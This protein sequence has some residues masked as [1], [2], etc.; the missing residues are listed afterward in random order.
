VLVF[1][2]VLVAPLFL[3]PVVLGG[4]L[5]ALLLFVP[6]FLLWVAR[7]VRAAA[8][9]HRRRAARAPTAGRR[10]S[11]KQFAPPVDAQVVVV[12]LPDPADRVL[13]VAHETDAALVVV[14]TRHRSAVGKFLLGS[15]AQR[16]VLEAACPVLVVKA[17]PV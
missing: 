8:R 2:A 17:E 9:D 4:Y 5:A 12:D 1:L 13:Q 11:G 10:R 7:G 16:L 15:T 3:A 14:G 6:A